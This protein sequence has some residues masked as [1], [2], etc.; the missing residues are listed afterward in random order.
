M[1]MKER[2]A[3]NYTQAISARNE[4]YKRNIQNLW[5]M[6]LSF[7]EDQHWTVVGNENG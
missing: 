1:L 4:H 2:L 7:I 6:R 5:S 3:K